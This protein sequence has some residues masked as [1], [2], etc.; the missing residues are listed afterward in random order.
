MRDTYA[1]RLCPAPGGGVPCQ[2]S[3]ISRSRETISPEC[4][5]SSARRARSRPPPICTAR[6]PSNAASGPSKQNLISGQRYGRCKVSASA[7]WDGGGCQP[8]PT[9]PQGRFPMKRLTPLAVIALACALIVPATGTAQRSKASSKTVT[10]NSVVKLSDFK[11]SDT[12][13]D[14]TGPGDIATFTLTTFDRAGKKQ[15]GGGHG[16]CILGVPKFAP[17][18][19]IISDGKGKIVLAWEDNGNST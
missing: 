18:T 12:T 7:C 2:S 8:I 1:S 19:A 14:G 17:C 15:T 11:V 4:T 10:I 6:S 9:G 5:R 13:G 16:Y 3:S